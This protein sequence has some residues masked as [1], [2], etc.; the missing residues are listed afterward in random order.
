MGTHDPHPQLPNKFT[1]Q[2][3]QIICTCLYETKISI[4]SYLKKG[5][6]LNYVNMLYVIGDKLRIVISS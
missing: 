5:K 1:N 6:N 2:D 3:T 4:A